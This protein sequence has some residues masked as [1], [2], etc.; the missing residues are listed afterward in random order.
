MSNPAI[1]DRN[2]KLPL[3]TENNQPHS[4]SRRL[5]L[6]LMSL[7]AGLQTGKS[8]ASP[9]ENLAER[10]F[11]ASKLF[12]DKT[13]LVIYRPQD[14]LQLAIS[15]TGYKKSP[16]NKSLI[17]TSSPNLLYVEF[18]PQSIA[19]QA[20]EEKGGEG[21]QGNFDSQAKDALTWNEN[22]T[23]GGLNL[24]LNVFSSSEKIFAPAKTYLS[25][26]TRLVFEIPASKTT[27]NLSAK[28]LLDWSGY[29]LIVSKRSECTPVFSVR[30]ELP[31]FKNVFDKGVIN[32]PQGQQQ[33][34]QRPVQHAPVSN[35][36]VNAP[37]NQPVRNIQINKTDTLKRQV[38]LNRDLRAATKDE[39]QVIQKN[40]LPPNAGIATNPG[41]AAVLA[42]LTMGKTP[43]PIPDSETSIE[44]PY[45]LFISPNQY[46]TWYH[47]HELKNREDLKGTAISTFELW[48]SKLM[49][50]NCRGVIDRTGATDI[51]KTIRA[52]WGT[53]IDGDWKDKPIR[54]F[55]PDG[56]NNAAASGRFVTSLY[57]DD[58]HCIVHQSSNFGINGFV[59]KSV[60]VKNLMLSTLG[61]WLDAELHFKRTELRNVLSDLNLLKWKHIAT[62]ARDH[63]VEV[64]Y[65]GNM[66][67]FGHEAALV[68]IT[69]RKPKD[70]F[71]ANWQR[72][73]I[74]INEEERKYNPYNKANGNFKQFPF[75]TIKFVTTVTPTI[76]PP[77]KF[78]DSVTSS[79]D[80]QFIPTVNGKSFNFKLTG[81]DMDG[82]ETDFEM[83]MV[84]VSTN[85][86]LTDT[87]NYNAGNIALLCGKYNQGDGI[88]NIVQF[89][90]QKMALA[91]SKTPGD[92]HFE[93][94]SIK[95]TS[96]FIDN[97]AP[98][99]RPRTEELDIFVSAIENLTGKRVATKI[100]LVDD[101]NKGTVFARLKGL[102]QEVNFTG[103]VNK[104]GGSLS[105]NFSVSALSKTLGAVGGMVNDLQNLKFNPE[106]F[107]DSNAKLFGVIELR[108]IIKAIETASTI[109]N[110]EQIESPIP[111]LKTIETGEA[112]ITQYVWKGATLKNFKYPFVEFIPEAGAALKIESNLYR[113]K[114]ASK[115]I[116]L[117][118]NSSIENFKVAIANIAAVKFK[119][120]GFFTGANSKT[121][122]TVE[123]DKPS[124]EFLG[125]LTFVNA[126]QKY[127]PADGFSDP[128]FLDI[129]PNGV[130]TG[131]TLA[132]PDIQL[133]AFT[134]RH[135]NLSAAVN[136]PFTGAPM[137]MRFNFCEKQ[138][139]FTLTVSAL[140]G[141]GFFAIEFDMNGLRSLEAALEFGA[142]VS[143]NLG[144]ASGGVSIMAGIY[145]K[146]T[147]QADDTKTYN[148]E[149]YVRINGALC[150]LGL[151]T[152]SVEFLL[153]LAGEMAN[154]GG[155]DKVVRVWGE[156]TLK[157]KVEVFMFSKTVKLKTT[158]EFAGAGADPTFGMMISKKEW[159]D[160]CG[161]FAV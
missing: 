12:A 41:I 121:D 103:S 39:Q 93:I 72:Y 54:D 27:I 71:A 136:L 86:S 125:P 81:Y 63:Y 145:F 124:V 25:G 76:Q 111:A 158:K 159:E 92:T 156:A 147:I 45:R 49:S 35:Q 79:A 30:D 143:I 102:S 82:N 26:T 64:V 52:L 19:E 109:V 6:K 142:A 46:A 61:A 148:I 132:L 160:Y 53:D 154:V 98:G 107:F 44:M 152:A 57:N 130:T 11:E 13:D 153:T 106:N 126:L 55:S 133:G 101:N 117:T 67:P 131:Y 22:K 90:N 108:K 84:F 144:V 32:I 96:V 21:G 128:P 37:T 157:I 78:H 66:L 155:K 104:T 10:L 70:G 140:G 43:R 120:V 105:P 83:P 40:E 91:R 42:D 48:H 141:G 59:P 5:L 161:S 3:L 50:T 62:L 100:S 129:T 14:L 112:Y 89:R 119:R 74:V 31:P 1:P 138:Q 137:S 149:G 99:F 116:A 17:R 20:F 16:D 58:R 29:K 18:Q 77:K 8:F 36:P 23:A 118:V 94:Q 75:S 88:N 69:E 65:A 123:M 115:P 38:Q 97:E 122:F 24:F 7:G 34:G 95:F 87:Q 2:Q 60:K 113:F 135:V 85:I 151:I 51:I 139:P 28:D 4:K 15:F 114:Q 73:F 110:G 33:P 68:R 127:I 150:V 47:E 146:V 9:D 56:S 80:Q 134:L